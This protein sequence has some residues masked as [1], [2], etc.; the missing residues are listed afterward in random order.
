M[1]LE[2]FDPT[3]TS[4]IDSARWSKSQRRAI[5]DTETNFDLEALLADGGTVETED[6]QTTKRKKYR[7]KGIY[8]GKMGPNDFAAPN[9]SE[10]VSVKTTD[11]G[12][13]KPSNRKRREKKTQSQ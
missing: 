10:E 12:R 9:M 7:I 6:L 1:I 5:V 2:C 4:Y 13:K 8:F 11:P 3:E